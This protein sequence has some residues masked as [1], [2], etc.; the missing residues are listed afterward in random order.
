M[1]RFL[2][3]VLDDNKRAELEH[4]VKHGDSHTFRR[5]CQ[6]VLLKADGRKSTEIAAIFG[7][8]E[9]SANDWLHRYLANGVAGLHIKTGC[10]CRSILSETADAEIVRCAVGEHRQ[11]I[12]QA[13]AALETATGK[14]F[15]QRTL[16]RFL[17]NLVA[18]INV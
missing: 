18:D 8:C 14:R 2:Q 13:K 10:R 3:I 15:S 16:V 12:G 17:K 9:K 5:H 6:I 11:R 1:G 4:G 7:C